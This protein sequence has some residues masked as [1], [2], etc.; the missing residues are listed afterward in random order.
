MNIVDIQPLPNQQFSATLADSFYDFTIQETNGVMS[1]SI[2][3][4]QIQIVQGQR[5]VAGSLVLPYEYQ[6]SG[7]FYF[8]NLSDELIYYPQFNIT[9]FLVF[10]SAADVEVMRTSQ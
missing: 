4:D 6:E 2:T 7:N 5:I 8:I 10:V 1:I 3:R 9:Q